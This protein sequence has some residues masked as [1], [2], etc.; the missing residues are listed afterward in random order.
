M[1]MSR[2][3]AYKYAAIDASC[4]I[5]EYHLTPT[6]MSVTVNPNAS[7]KDLKEVKQYLN[8]VDATKVEQV[9]GE[10]Q[11]KSW[12]GDRKSQSQTNITFQTKSQ[13]TS[14]DPPKYITIIASKGKTDAYVTYTS[15][16]WDS[17]DTIIEAMR[18]SSQ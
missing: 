15:D 12:H 18:S 3:L 13:K 4:L 17:A 6:T 1:H 11:Y 5:L 8:N 7:K 16:T 2:R 10:G 14:G 9:Y